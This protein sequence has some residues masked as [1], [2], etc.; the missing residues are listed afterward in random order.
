MELIIRAL[1][2][3]TVI[4]IVTELAK[5]DSMLAAIIAA[6]PW[7]SIISFIWLYY[8]KQSNQSIAA[9]SMKILW[10]IIPSLF[11]FPIL[12]CCLRNGINFTYSMTISITVMSLIYL[13]YIHI[14]PSIK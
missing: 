3:G 12:S 11:F 7:I 8:D 6:L 13:V 5:K 2:S 14:L 10:F 9:L 4:V 1:I